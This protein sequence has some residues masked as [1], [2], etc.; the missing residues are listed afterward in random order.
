MW[1]N[2]QI[3][4]G[5]PAKFLRDLTTEEVTFIA[6]NANNYMG[7]AEIHSTENSKTFGEIEADKAQRRK[8]D[9]QSD[10]YDSHLGITRSKRPQIAFPDKMATKGPH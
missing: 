6:V 4:A 3:W 9:Q 5:S 1:V 8:W 10:D 2:F 7:L